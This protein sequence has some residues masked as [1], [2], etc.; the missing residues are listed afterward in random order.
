[1]QIWLA[2]TSHYGRWPRNVRERQER[3]D[4][5]RQRLKK[6]HELFQRIAG[7][8]PTPIEPQRPKIYVEFDCGFDLRLRAFWETSRVAVWS[9]KDHGFEHKYCPFLAREW[10]RINL[11][12]S[13]NA[14]LEGRWGDREAGFAIE[15]K[16]QMGDDFPAV[17][18]QMKRNGADT[19]VI[20]S[21]EA[22]S[23]TLAQVRSM[24]GDKRIITLNEIEAVQ[25]RG[26]WPTH[27][28]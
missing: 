13:Y 11:N 7:D 26:A 22:T 20:G 27:D 6:E 2:D 19:L 5:R 23:C 25:E 24:F 8:I 3:L 16:P 21:F 28:A 10:E 18:R 14:H 15:L 12:Q 9:P 1:M 4:H 17:L